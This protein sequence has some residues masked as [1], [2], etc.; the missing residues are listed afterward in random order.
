MKARIHTLISQMSQQMYER[1][2]VIAQ[3]LLAAVAGSHTFIRLAGHGQK[4]DFQTGCS[5][6]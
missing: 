1:E 6:F 5:R 4:P 3:T 2:Q